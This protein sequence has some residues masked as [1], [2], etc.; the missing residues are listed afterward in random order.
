[1][2]ASSPTHRILA[3]TSIVATLGLAA[4][5]K[6]PTSTQNPDQNQED[7]TQLTDAEAQAKAERLQRI[8]ELEDREKELNDRLARLE[9]SITESRENAP[10]APEVSVPI[11]APRRAVVIEE[12][13]A[14]R[15]VLP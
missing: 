5:D 11:P 4:C 12:E 10:T 2:K 14:P 15:E 9:K 7:N 13:P 1:M 6:A 8:K 3:V